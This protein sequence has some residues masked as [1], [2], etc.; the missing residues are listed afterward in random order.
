MPRR[1]G[2][3]HSGGEPPVPTGRATPATSRERTGRASPG[4]L[5]PG[6]V[7]AALASAGGETRSAEACIPSPARGEAIYQAYNLERNAAGAG[8]GD[9]LETRLAAYRRLIAATLARS[10]VEA[11]CRLEI[12]RRILVER[13]RELRGMS[14][15]AV[16]MAAPGLSFEQMEQQVQS[17]LSLVRELRDEL[18]GTDQLPPGWE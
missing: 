10:R 3:S 4:P 9:T 15:G 17:E 12:A 8:F 6:L 14:G 7:L 18:R 16:I 2:P 11:P 13:E 5:L 1:I